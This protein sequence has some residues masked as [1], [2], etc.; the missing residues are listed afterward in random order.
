MRAHPVIGERL[1]GELRS[2]VRVRPIVRHHH[3]RLDGSGYPDGLRG[4]QI[5]L[6]A[7]ITGLVDVYDALTTT[8][9]YREALSFDDAAKALHE[10]VSRGWRRKELVDLLLELAS[11]N[12]LDAPRSMAG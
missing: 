1:C 4:T 3:E 8:R 5:P 9:P 2:L 10:E 12:A 6:L 11:S 7:E